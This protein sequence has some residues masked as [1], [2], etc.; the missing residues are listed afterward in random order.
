MKPTLP[1][2]DFQLKWKH[3]AA[4]YVTKPNIDDTD[5]YTPATVQSLIDEAYAAGQA[6]ALDSLPIEPWNVGWAIRPSHEA[7][8]AF[9]DY[10]KLNGE[11]HKHGFYESTWGAI[12]RALRAVTPSAQQEK[13]K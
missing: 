1:E 7:A 11:T 4:Y 13:D 8:I 5:V 3:D 10:W 9:W 6:D 12:N 2:P